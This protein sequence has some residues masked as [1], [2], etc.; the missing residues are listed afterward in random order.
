MFNTEIKLFTWRSR[1]TKK[2][3]KSG[4]AEKERNSGKRAEKK[5]KSGNFP[6][7]AEKV[8]TLDITHVISH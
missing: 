6:Q 2:A 8:A 7:K 1:K 4:T 5:R 3:E